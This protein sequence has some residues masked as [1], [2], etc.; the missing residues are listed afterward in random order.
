MTMFCRPT[1]A[2]TF[3]VA[4]ASLLVMPVQATAAD[5]E[6]IPVDGAPDVYI[7]RHKDLQAIFIVTS[8][9][10]IAT[11]PIS[12]KSAGAAAKY[13]AEI[14]KITS[15]PIKYVIYSHSG[16][17]R[18]GGGQLFKDEGAKFI[19]HAEARKVLEK[20]Q[21][22]HLKDFD[23]IIP[24]ETVDENNP[25]K[26]TL[27]GRDV[28]VKDVGR[29]YSND[30]LVVLLP[31]EKVLFAVD[32]IPLKT[33]PSGNMA[34]S[35]IPGWEKSLETVYNDADW[36]KLVLGRRYN[37]QGL[38]M[39]PDVQAL[40]DYFTALSAEVKNKVSDCWAIA[41]ADIKLPAFETW[42]NYKQDLPGNVERYCYYWTSK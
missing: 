40:R 17:E 16:L 13:L 18:S 20:Q 2:S 31:K 6:T 1:V 34:R 41:M 32:F 14:K 37:D 12:H 25:R 19:A 21:S 23:A 22:D 3:A 15:N 5:F 7:F 36:E 9:G 4:F 38:A 33:L 39:K 30:M 28:I 26:I 35:W 24:D 10:V 8:A 11:D 29:N 42:G 27:G